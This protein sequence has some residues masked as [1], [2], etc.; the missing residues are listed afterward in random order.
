LG[1]RGGGRDKP[2][3]LQDRH[4]RQVLKEPE[5]AVLLDVRLSKS[6][7]SEND[8]ATIHTI[9]NSSAL[10]SENAVFVHDMELFGCRLFE[11]YCT[12]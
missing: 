7:Q 1:L 8:S 11:D 12:V 10:Q 9:S 5:I 2:S 6:R 4:L 3:S